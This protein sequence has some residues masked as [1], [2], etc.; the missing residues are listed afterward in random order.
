MSIIKH[1]KNKRKYKKNPDLL[2]KALFDALEI[3]DNKAFA[4]LCKKHEKRILQNFKLWLTIPEAITNNTDAVKYYG[5]KLL[6]I[7]RHFEDKG[8]KTLV[9]LLMKNDNRNP[10]IRWN[11][12]HSRVDELIDNQKNNEA[13]QILQTLLNDMQS[14]KGIG[15]ERYISKTIG[16]LGICYFNM[17]KHHRAISSSEKAFEL[18]MRSNDI[19][20]ALIYAANLETIYQQANDLEKITYWKVR[21]QQILEQVQ[22]LTKK[23]TKKKLRP[24]QQQQKK[25]IASPEHKIVDY[26][27]IEQL[28][29]KIQKKLYNKSGIPEKAIENYYKG[30]LQ[31]EK[32]EYTLALDWFKQALK[33]APNWS[34]PL[35]DMAYVLLFLG[36]RQKAYNLYIQVDK[37]HPRGFYA[38]KTAIHTL[39]RE[40]KAELPGDTYKFF[41]TIKQEIDIDKKDDLLDY[42]LDRCTNFAPAWLEKYKTVN[43]QNEQLFCLSKGIS[44]DSD[45]ET[46]GLML[47]NQAVVFL[48]SNRKTEAYNILSELV[49]DKNLTLQNEHLAKAL[50]AHE[51]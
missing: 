22:Y 11:E 14:K 30:R 13:V 23:N 43:S 28:L 32:G 29:K 18:C 42:L 45:A 17:K 20:G 15:I 19:D 10:F 25:T 4:H 38:V 36:E 12:A 47:I 49:F 44:Y 34:Y 39:E 31:G 2:R 50:L 6:H 35:Y 27:T 46:K 41:L 21:Q 37:M 48:N 1:I 24:R 8:N 3:K 51:Y 5:M 7:A 40:I 9:E 33:I 16:M 26:Q